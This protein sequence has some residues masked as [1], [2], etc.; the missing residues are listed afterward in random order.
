MKRTLRLLSTF[1]FLGSVGALITV[2]RENQDP[3]VVPVPILVEP[4][5]PPAFAA[6]CTRPTGPWF[7]EMVD[8]AAA[9]FA[10]DPWLV[11]ATVY[12]E[13]GCDVT[14][15]GSSGEIGLG[16]VNPKV[17]PSTLVQA[18][19]IRQV[20]D[21]WDAATNLRA[22]AFILAGLHR[23][24]GGDVFETFRRYN[25]SGPKARAY[26]REQVAVFVRITGSGVVGN[27]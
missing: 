26:A 14:A 7:D 4:P 25:G 3:V 19:V 12:R 15:L 22:T 1:F 20:R 13:S 2:I 8:S 21:L 5:R 9:E 6:H 27:P 23:E 17:W 16:Q 18:G 11:A 10:V 24:T